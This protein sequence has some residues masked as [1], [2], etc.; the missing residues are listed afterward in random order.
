[1]YEL[2]I[3]IYAGVAHETFLLDI[4]YD[5]EVQVLQ[6]PQI[7]I[8]IAVTVKKVLHLTIGERLLDDLQHKLLVHFRALRLGI[9]FKR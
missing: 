9:A 6:K 7:L 3:G 4:G 2:T 8:R 5:K 1:M